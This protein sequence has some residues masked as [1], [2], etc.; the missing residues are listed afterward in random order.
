M[1]RIAVLTS[2]RDAPGMNA[3]VR[4][5]VRSAVAEGC[6]VLGV[7]DGFR[8]LLSASYEP[9]GPREVSS[10]LRR[11]GTV[12]GSSA[13]PEFAD[14]EVR[15]VA[16][17]TLRQHEVD[18]VVVIGGDGSQA[19]VWLRAE[20]RRR[21]RSQRRRH[22]D[23]PPEDDR[24]VAPSGISGRGDGRSMRPSGA[25]GGH[26]R[27][28]RS[29]RHPGGGTDPRGSGTRGARRVWARQAHAIIVVAEGAR[30]NGQ[31]LAAHFRGR[32]E[33][34]GFEPRLTVLGHVQRGGVPTAF[35][36]VLATRLGV[37]AVEHLTAGRPGCMVGWL[38]GEVTMTP[39]SEVATKTKALDPL[40]G[41]A[42]ML[43]R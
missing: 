10:I 11:G 15:M 19:G 4:A 31:R 26:R 23:R 29:D 16:L 42:G 32:G 13:C 43:A 12:L 7:R 18:A 9:L 41:M 14:H 30:W 37:A 35:D 6:T 3:A 17:R 5:V 27:R 36:R 28:G 21:H 22:R 39:L 40:L 34:L 8:G 33:Q 25:H 2:G 38:R 1:N 20:H 24:R